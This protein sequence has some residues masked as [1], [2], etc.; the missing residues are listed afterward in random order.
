MGFVDPQVASDEHRAEHI[1]R[2]GAADRARTDDI[3]LGKLTLYQLSYSRSQSWELS[4]STIGKV[5]RSE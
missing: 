4:L 3:Q 1:T 2:T 5:S